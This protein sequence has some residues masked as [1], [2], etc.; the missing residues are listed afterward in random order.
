LVEAA[1]NMGPA[2]SK[3]HIVA[4]GERAISGAQEE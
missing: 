4:A 1:A 3:L 2:E